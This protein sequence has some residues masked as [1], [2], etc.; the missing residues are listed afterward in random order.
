MTSYADVES[1]LRATGL[2]A[3]GAFHPTP[4]DLVPDAPG[5]GACATLVMV[6]NAGPGM[7]RVFSRSPEFG[8]AGHALDAW[9]ARVIGDVATALDARALFPFGGPPYLPFLRWAARAERVWPSPLGM[10]IHPEYGLWHAYRGALALRERID[11]AP[12]PAATRPCDAC[13]DQPCL[14]ACPVGAFTAA[15]YDVPGC[16]T[17]LSVPAGDACMSGGCLARHACPVGQRYAYAPAQSA[18]HMG[19][20]VNARREVVGRDVSGRSRPSR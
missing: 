4:D 5:G 18:L 20:F 9:S 15:G 3:R 6:G 8:R 17:R 16:V 10:L 14:N 7:W 11:L 19:A 1:R 2:V 12:R 13:A